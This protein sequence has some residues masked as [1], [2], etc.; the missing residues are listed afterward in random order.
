MT[1]HAAGYA[2]YRACLTLLATSA[3]RN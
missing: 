1:Y 3:K 2:S